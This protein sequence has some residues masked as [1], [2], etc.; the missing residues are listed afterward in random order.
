VDINKFI[1]IGPDFGKTI[2]QNL[3]AESLSH[4]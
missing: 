2:V 4:F 1:R 3:C